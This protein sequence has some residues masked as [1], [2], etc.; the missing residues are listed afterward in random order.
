MFI[1]LA[2]PVIGTSLLSFPKKYFDP[3]ALFW[4]PQMYGP[5]LLL[6]QEENHILIL[7]A[8][9]WSLEEINVRENELI[10]G[11]IEGNTL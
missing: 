7:Y 11:Q 8:A 1:S 10:A 6:S 4:R 5:T 9:I 3:L 2:L